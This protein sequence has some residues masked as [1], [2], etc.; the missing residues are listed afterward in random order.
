MKKLF[1][2]FIF[3]VAVLTTSAQVPMKLNYQAVARDAGGN[4]LANQLVCLTLN[5]TD[6][7]GGPAL[8]TEDYTL[9]TNQFGL[10][11][12]SIGGG[13]PSSFANIDWF[14][15]SPW[16]NVS[17]DVGCIGSYTDMGSSQL[18]SVPYALNAISSMDNHWATIGDNIHNSNSGNVG[19][20]TYS[21]A[22]M[23]HVYGGDMLVESTGGSSGVLLSHGSATTYAPSSGVSQFVSAYD[24]NYGWA[25]GKTLLTNNNYH[26]SNL[27][28]A[29]DND[30]TV[31]DA[32]GFV[33]I[34]MATP[35]QKLDVAGAIRIGDAAAAND[36]TIRY[37]SRDF[38]GFDGARWKSFI[39]N[40]HQSVGA[41]GWTS[42]LRN[43][44]VYSD[45]SIVVADSGLYLVTMSIKGIHGSAYTFPTSDWDNDGTAAVSVNNLYVLDPIVTIFTLYIDN[46][47]ATSYAKYIKESPACTRIWR[48]NQG[49][50]LKAG[51]YVTSTG[52]P[53][54]NWQVEY[55]YLD[56]VKVAD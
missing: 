45:D 12:L 49:D 14:N 4:T 9:T 41:S 18:L 51:A 17:M 20:G 29:R 1:F 2:L 47:G 55:Y 26:I 36:G 37:S 43:T 6:G 22:V 53:T 19:I 42:N 5:I 11:T 40:E 32:S 46:S 30:I 25:M 50:V 16:V 13:D 54:D 23:L 27:T 56:I 38:A 52:A 7:S 34:G 8:Y 39:S 15:T 48:F 10:F 24:A 31:L 21:P 33:G 3:L 44:W 35:L 28:F